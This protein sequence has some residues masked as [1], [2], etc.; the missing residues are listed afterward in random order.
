MGLLETKNAGRMT[1]KGSSIPPA[2]VTIVRE[3]I[4]VVKGG[5]RNYLE[6]EFELTLI[7]TTVG[8]VNLPTPLNDS[9]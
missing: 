1:S 2:K 9:F 5:Q 3:H 6:K 4:S 7:V 8:C